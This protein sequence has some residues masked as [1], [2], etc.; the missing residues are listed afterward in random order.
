MEKKTKKSEEKKTRWLGNYTE[1]SLSPF[2]SIIAYVC[3]S[4]DKLPLLYTDRAN[5]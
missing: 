2:L 3:T 5:N 1:Q 4:M